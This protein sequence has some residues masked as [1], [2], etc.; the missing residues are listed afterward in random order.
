LSVNI[1]KWLTSRAA[2]KEVKKG[3]NIGFRED[4]S[5]YNLTMKGGS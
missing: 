2:G 5:G 3:E 1:E 4:A